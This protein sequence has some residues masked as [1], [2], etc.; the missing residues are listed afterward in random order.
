MDQPSGRRRT[1]SAPRLLCCP[2]D[3]RNRL[4][5]AGSS[6]VDV[7]TA[8]LEQSWESAEWESE[9]LAA[10]TAEPC[11]ETVTV[12]VAESMTL[13]AVPPHEAL[14]DVTPGPELGFL[15]AATEPAELSDDQALSAAAACQRQRGWVDARQVRVLAQFAATR[16]RLDP[17]VPVEPGRER[18]L[19][20]GG[21]GTPPVEE[22]A[23]AE[24]GAVL[25][26][27]TPSARNR[28]ADALDLVHRHPATLAALEAGA[29]DDF[30]RSAAGPGNA[31]A[32]RRRGCRGR[33]QAAADAGPLVTA[34][35]A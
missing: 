3:G 14:D 32:P 8:L 4:S 33:G 27:S 1:P 11:T 17:D 6:V 12:S 34:G 13:D 31:P 22:F 15:L 18:M 24:V 25:G 29:V 26:L 20:L 2:D 5:A 7:G 19:R 21:Q 30:R 23:A 9:F 10:L 35:G 28:L 16:A